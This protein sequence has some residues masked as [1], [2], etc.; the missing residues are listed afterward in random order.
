MALKRRVRP[1]HILDVA[2]STSGINLNGGRSITRF[3]FADF[4]SWRDGA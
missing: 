2:V 4:V 3:S 1:T